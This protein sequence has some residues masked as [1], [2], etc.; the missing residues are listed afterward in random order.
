M[1]LKY[2][3]FIKML[4]LLFYLT[5]GI[6]AEWQLQNSQ[7]Q[8]D[9]FGI[10]FISTSKGFA[11]GDHG[12]V[13]K[14]TDGGQTW[15]NINIAPYWSKQVFFTDYYH[16]WICGCKSILY[17][18]DGGESWTQQY[19]QSGSY[20]SNC[21]N[22]IYF[23]NNSTGF[24]AGTYRESSSSNDKLI[25][26]KTN[27]SGQ[28]WTQI[29]LES[30]KNPQKILFSNS[31]EGWLAGTTGVLNQYVFEHTNDGGVTWE[32]ISPPYS[33]IFGRNE[34][35]KV[36]NYIINAGYSDGISP[37]RI[38]KS[39]DGLN[40]PSYEIG[41]I[42][43]VYS[44][45]FPSLYNG[46]A[47]KSGGVFWHSTDI[48]NTWTSVPSPTSETIEDIFF[49]NDNLGWACGRNGMLMKYENT[50]KIDASKNISISS[51]HLFHN[52][53]NPFNPVTQIKYRLV[54][55]E[56]VNLSVYNSF[57]QKVAILINKKISPGT[58]TVKFDGSGLP[59]GVYFYRLKAGAFEQTRKMLLLR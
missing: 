8:E 4:V 20:P 57:G 18:N 21:F 48:G 22:T 26:Y 33:S 40:W 12:V 38:M 14:T 15:H 34:L 2:V 29:Y 53:P 55:T 50:S 17:T 3:F 52:Y 47:G 46:W 56:N 13:L 41:G 24:V 7:T 36:S 54:K 37:S 51:I 49:L 23:I 10:F 5:P 35:V 39:S 44:L 11:V 27:N 30:G 58:Y 31:Q 1:N 19:W 9:L 43:N 28:S 59:S 32:R 45:C 25:I 16:G 6:C 42:T